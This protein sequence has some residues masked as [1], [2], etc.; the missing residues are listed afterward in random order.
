M[1]LQDVQ[2]TSLESRVALAAEHAVQKVAAARAAI[3][4]VIFGQEQVV[5][6]LRRSASCWASARS[7]SNSRRT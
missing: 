1:S 7:A 2:P 4:L 6:W 3:G 5:D